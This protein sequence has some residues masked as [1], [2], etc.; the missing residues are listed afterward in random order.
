MTDTTHTHDP[1]E[2]KEQTA[3]RVLAGKV[4]LLDERVEALIKSLDAGNARRISRQDRQSLAVHL[5][6]QM[7]RVRERLQR[8]SDQ[9]GADFVFPSQVESFVD[10]VTS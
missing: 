10:R 7:D 6:K 2:T 1:E 9:D 4:R 5:D 3:T 8:P